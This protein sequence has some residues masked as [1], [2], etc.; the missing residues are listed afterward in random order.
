MCSIDVDTVIS[1][2]PI[3]MV[4]ARSQPSDD[5]TLIGVT[6]LQNLKKGKVRQKNSA[7]GCRDGT[8]YARPVEVCDSSHV[9]ESSRG[10]ARE[11]TPLKE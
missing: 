5:M 6:G 9:E 8:F 7:L 3:Q 4:K 10:G 1:P 2:H 11:D